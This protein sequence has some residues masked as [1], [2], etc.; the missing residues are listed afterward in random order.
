MCFDQR[1]K[2]VGLR[3]A[4]WQLSTVERTPYRILRRRLIRAFNC[5][6]YLSLD[7]HQGGHR[8]S[9]SLFSI[10]LNRLLPLEVHAG[11]IKMSFP[12]AWNQVWTLPSAISHPPHGSQSLTLL[13]KYARIENAVVS[14]V[15]PFAAR[16]PERHRS[17]SAVKATDPDILQRFSIRTRIP[18]SDRRRRPI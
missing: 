1:D 17:K 8:H 4:P 10:T 18:P 2:R 7:S 14:S 9:M 6:T 16:R 15:S 12:C 5:C 13:W 3:I 11:S